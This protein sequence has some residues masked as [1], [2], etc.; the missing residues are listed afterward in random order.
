[1]RSRT[2]ILII[3]VL[4][5]VGL[6]AIFLVPQLLDSGGG[7][8]TVEGGAAE[9]GGEEPGLP[10][11]E[12][13]ETQPT[14]TPLPLPVDVVIAKIDLPIGERIRSE[15]LTMEQRPDDNIA[16]Q[17]GVAFTNFDDVVGKIARVPISKGEAI[18]APMVSAQEFFSPAD[19]ILSG[20]DLALFVDQ[21]MVA[22]SFP[23]DKYSGI[24]YA[25]RPGDLVDIMMTLRIVEIDPEFNTALPNDTRRVI[26]SELLAGRAFLFPATTQ[27]RLE[28]IPEINQA[29]EFIPKPVETDAEDTEGFDPSPPIPKRVTQLT[30]QQAK[31]MWVGTWRDAR[32]FEKEEVVVDGGA[33]AGLEE[34]PLPGEEAVGAEAAVEPTPIPERFEDNPDVI[35]LSMLSQDALVLKWALERGLDIDLA[36]RSQGDITVYVTTSVSLPQIIDQGGLSIPEPADFDL[37]P[38]VDEVKPPSLP[39][40]PPEN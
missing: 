17:G 9:A 6:L 37:Y 39:P 18:L 10:P 40:N 25:L 8:V 20:S 2:F 26:E 16:L 4:I 15:V 33:V 24:G 13:A 14:A 19:L 29:V 1:M 32:E 5:A 23:I 21:G 7:E 22:V 3:L 11:P 36:L 28:F 35:I 12:A 38:R 30:I 31:V 34:A 27:G